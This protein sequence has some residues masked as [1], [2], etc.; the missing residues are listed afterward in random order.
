MGA[1]PR[2]ILVV[3]QLPSR[4]IK[5]GAHYAILL[6]TGAFHVSQ[7][8]HSSMAFARK[9]R[10]LERLNIASSELFFAICGVT[11]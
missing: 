7:D 9:T 5:V 8:I 2:K 10:I 1:L 3:Q 11:L 6:V 4:Q